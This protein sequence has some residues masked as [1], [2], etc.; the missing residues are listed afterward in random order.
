MSSVN[1]VMLVGRAGKDAE[2]RYFESGQ[3]VASFSLATSEKYKG[4][5]E[6]EWHNV[7]IWGKSADNAANLIKKGSLVYVEGKIKSRKWTTKEG[8]ERSA[9][10][11]DCF[12]FTLL[13]GGG[14]RESQG[15]AVK[16]AL[17]DD[18]IDNIPF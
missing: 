6:T 1:K 11:I 5:E 17:K 3:G 2:V 18:D 9:V 13:G 16:A 10:Q 14:K 4:Q 8:V 15:E 7:Q 12:N